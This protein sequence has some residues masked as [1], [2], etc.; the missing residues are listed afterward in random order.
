MPSEETFVAELLGACGSFVPL[1]AEQARTLYRHWTILLR[2][3]PIVGLTTI[4]DPEEAIRWHYFDSLFLAALLPRESSHVLDLGSGGG[5]PGIPIAVYRPDCRVWLC[6]RALKKA[7]FLKEATRGWENVKV[8]R[9]VAAGPPEGY[10]WLVSRAVRFDE[11]LEVAL[12]KAR[13]LGLLVGAEVA[14]SLRSDHR[15]ELVCER[16]VPGSDRRFAILA[17]VVKPRTSV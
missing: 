14:R 2:W 13:W 7:A 11:I 6:E 17:R 8:I 9:D 16:S 5:F 3:N 4:T 1:R 10:D 15:V 12:A